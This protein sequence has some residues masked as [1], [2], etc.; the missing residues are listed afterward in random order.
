M[1][2]SLE[3]HGLPFKEGNHGASKLLAVLHTKRGGGGGGGGAAV[4]A[5]CMASSMRMTCR[6]HLLTPS[7]K[8][9]LSCLLCAHSTTEQL[10]GCNE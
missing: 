1:R 4:V 3:T 9:M 5:L 8:A 2:V 6:L 7:L 10:R